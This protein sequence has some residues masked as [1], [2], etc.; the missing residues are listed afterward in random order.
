[1]ELYL[2]HV[3]STKRSAYYLVEKGSEN[4]PCFGKLI[5]TNEVHL[6][7]DKNIQNEAFV[8]VGQPCFLVPEVKGSFINHA[9]PSFAPSH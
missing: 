1:M 5:G 8:R 9:N 2:E 3:Y 6:R 7:S 4:P